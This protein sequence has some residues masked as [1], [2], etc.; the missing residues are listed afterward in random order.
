MVT[1][2]TTKGNTELFF[3]SSVEERV[4]TDV[5]D[6]VTA[7]GVGSLAVDDD[8]TVAEGTLLLN[9]FSFYCSRRLT[10]FVFVEVK[11]IK[12]GNLIA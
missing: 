5:V 12:K 10:V 4:A 6:S 11:A 8:S 9:P 7:A 1:S 3:D 2:F